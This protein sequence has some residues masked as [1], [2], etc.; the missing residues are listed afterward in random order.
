MIIEKKCKNDDRK[1][2]TC[3][4]MASINKRKERSNHTLPR[5]EIRQRKQSVD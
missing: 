3:V 4:L 1:K 2:N 5:A